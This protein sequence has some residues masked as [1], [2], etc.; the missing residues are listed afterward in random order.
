M[1]ELVG[2]KRRLYAS[3]S[4][5]SLVADYFSHVTLRGL[6]GNVNPTPVAVS[7]Y[8]YAGE[9]VKG[10]LVYSV[11]AMTHDGSVD[12][13]GD[14]DSERISSRSQ[15]SF[16]LRGIEQLGAVSTRDDLAA[17]LRT[18]H[19]RADKPSLRTLEARTR[20]SPTSLSKTVVAEM[21]K[22][23]RFPRKAVMATFVQAC[24][25]PDGAL[26]PWLRAWERVAASEE[27]PARTGV[28]RTLPDGQRRPLVAEHPSFPAPA[29]LQPSSGSAGEVQLHSV[30][31]D[32][33]SSPVTAKHAEIMPLR[34]Q[35]SQLT[36]R[37]GHAAQAVL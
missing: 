24:G 36:D 23:A 25:V 20:H 7:C 33:P 31:A 37:V 16:D 27:A 22:G 12:V 4:G 21:L 17:L 9:R 5:G 13:S 35:I 3:T 19:V 2:R 1:L 34:E 6:S 28:A 14:N 8:L 30:P 32:R 15:C 10:A 29:T 11:V 18:V 26:E